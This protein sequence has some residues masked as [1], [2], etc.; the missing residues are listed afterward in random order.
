MRAVV[1]ARNSDNGVRFLAISDEFSMRH[2]RTPAEQDGQQSQELFRSRLDG[3]IA[4]SHPLVKLSEKMPWETISDRVAP[5]L[6]PTP[7]GAG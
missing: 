3:M 1:I 6:P 2:R 4:L 7:A 5:V